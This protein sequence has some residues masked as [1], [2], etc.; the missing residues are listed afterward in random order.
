MVLESAI[1][2]RLMTFEAAEQ[3]LSEASQRKQGTLRFLD[4][5]AASGTETRVR[6]FLQQRQ[7]QARTQVWIPGVGR[8]DMLVGRSLILECDSKAHHSDPEE[9]RRRDLAARLLGY[10]TLR[11]SYGQVFREWEATQ[12]TLLKILRTGAHLLPPRP[13]SA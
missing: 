13:R 10:D 5:G 7:F 11:L 8:V 9:D 4:R 12:L 6:L 1:D 3:L 2:R